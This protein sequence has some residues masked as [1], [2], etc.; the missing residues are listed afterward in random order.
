M[1]LKPKQ[2]HSKRKLS[3]RNN[4]EEENG[5]E[6][7]CRIILIGKILPDNNDHYGLEM[8]LNG[9]NKEFTIEKDSPVMPNNSIL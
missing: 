1:T 5:T 9:K 4:L 2:H 6:E 3:G 7:I 8:K